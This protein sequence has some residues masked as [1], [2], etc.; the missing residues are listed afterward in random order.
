MQRLQKLLIVLRWRDILPV[1]GSQNLPISFGPPQHYHSPLRNW[2]WGFFQR[3]FT[4]TTCFKTQGPFQGI[5]WA[6]MLLLLLWGWGEKPQMYFS[7]LCRSPWFINSVP[8]LEIQAWTSK[9]C[10]RP[11][12]T[13]ISL[14]TLHKRLFTKAITS[15]AY[16]WTKA[17]K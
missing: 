17:Y 11:P 13:T 7:I 8:G 10:I 4:L 3:A 9:I 1:V 14:R 5:K 6:E 16:I 15:M 2:K 12:Q